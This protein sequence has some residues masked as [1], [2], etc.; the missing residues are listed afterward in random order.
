MLSSCQLIYLYLA[1]F[2]S[3]FFSSQNVHWSIQQITPLAA[4]IGYILIILV[5][6]CS[7]SLPIIFFWNSLQRVLLTEVIQLIFIFILTLLRF[8]HSWQ[9]IV[10]TF[11]ACW[12]GQ[13]TTKLTSR[14]QNQGMRNNFQQEHIENVEA[15]AYCRG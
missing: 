3:S 8:K 14:I 10:M 15:G 2:V 7:L 1:F 5:T 6:T 13:Q 11:P 9:H 12:I 4:L